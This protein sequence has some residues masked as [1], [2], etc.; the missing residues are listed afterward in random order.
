M[1]W[2]KNPPSSGGGDYGPQISELQNKTSQ[3]DAAIG[4][5]FN[6]ADS[7]LDRVT[8]LEGKPDSID[9]TQ[10]INEVEIKN[11]L[12]DTRLTAIDASLLNKAPLVSGKVPYDNLPEFPVGRKV[13]V[14]NRAA[15]LAL[16]SYA[17]LTIAYE[18]DTGDAYGLDANSAPNID[19]NWSKLGNALGVGVA[20]F[21]GRTGNIGPQTGDYITSMIPEAVGKRYV[22]PEQITQWTNAATATTVTTF[23]GRSG[24]VVPVAGDYTSDLI[25]ESVSKQFISA[26]EKLLISTINTRLTALEAKAAYVR[27]WKQYSLTTER[28]QNTWYTNTTPREIVVDAQSNTVSNFVFLRIEIKANASAAVF[29]VNSNNA[30]GTVPFTAKVTAEIPA[31]WMYRVTDNAGG[32][33]RTVARWIEFS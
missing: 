11:S 1:T 33:T 22:T 21:N 10:A 29:I 24:V 14:A 15:R 32:S 4:L 19:S 28:V 20:S 25:T 13:N 18:G 3:Q 30:N 12:Q 2:L 9:Y 31:G 27:T 7:I 16:S 8:V 5:V 17:D 26:S 6:K 23:K